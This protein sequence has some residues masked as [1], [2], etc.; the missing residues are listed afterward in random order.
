MK[1]PYGISAFEKII[2]QGYFFCDRTDRIPRLET[3]GD[4]LLF[5]RPRRFGKSLLVS[6][7]A[8][9]YDIAKKDRFGELF[10][11]LAIGRNPTPLAGRY[12]ILWLDFSVVE[13]IG[14][15][16]DIRRS[17]HDHI[18]ACI[19]DFAIRYK[20]RLKMRLEIDRENALSSLQRMI[21][22]LEAAGIPLYLF[23]DEYDNF[24]NEVMT[25]SRLGRETYEGLVGK[26]GVLKTLFKA[27]KSA[28]GKGGIDRLFIT[29]VSPVVLSDITSGFN[30]AENIYLTPEFNDLCGFTEAE[31]EALAKRVAVERGDGEAKA[32]EA[33]SLMRTFYNG[34]TF[35]PRSAARIYNPT[36]ALYFL[37][38]LHRQGCY[39]RNLLDANLAAD[40][41]KLEYAAALPNG[42]QML[43]DIVRETDNPVVADISDRFG[44]RDMLDDAAK[45][46][47]F[48]ASFL[49]YFG[50]LTIAGKTAEAELALGVPNLVARGLY[51]E[52]IGEMLLPKAITRDD[53]RD[54]AKQVYQKGD[55]APLAEFVETRYFQVFRNRDYRWANELTV[56]TAFL[57]LLY[58]DI[59]YIMDSERETGRG[60]PDLT[61][62]IRPDMR[63]FRILDVLI[64]FKFV[65]PKHAG[66]TGEAARELSPE[67]LREIP[68][69]VSEME[70]AREQLR[71][72]GDA[73]EQ[74]HGNLRLRRFAVVSLG[75]ERIW[76]EGVETATG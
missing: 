30:I 26:E 60:Y 52:K 73:L 39:P 48:V 32:K 17:L 16:A 10:G 75:F 69:M 27:I 21:S 37:K 45:G 4:Q 49:Y 38:E 74:R 53:G 31:V 61:M 41:T 35:S 51:V 47:G 23:I 50:V 63:R 36:L 76:W 33:L 5:I 44:L 72:Y 14:A 18:N 11:H 22:A 65:T 54:A 57:T 8:H 13:P 7:L 56:K 62:I 71:R 40:S 64:E 46:H 34:Y 20:D 66:M 59:L 24:A 29:G 12:A 43:L 15:P 68:A 6:I 42:R 67:A 1:F 28:A 25:A 3:A 55:M 19:E 2:T 9:Y 58:N 70:A